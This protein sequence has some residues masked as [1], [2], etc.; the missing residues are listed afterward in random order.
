M[1]PDIGQTFTNLFTIAVSAVRDTRL[2]LVQ[3][4]SN[5]VVGALSAWVAGSF[6]VHQG[7]QR[8]QRERA[9]ERRLTWF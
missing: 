4:V 9:F 2:D 7:L 5:I 3:L 8:A 6:G 1:G